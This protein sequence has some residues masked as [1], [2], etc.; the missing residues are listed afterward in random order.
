MW[1]WMPTS[2]RVNMYGWEGPELA[3]GKGAKRETVCRTRRRKPREAPLKLPSLTSAE[4]AKC[5]SP[6]R[7]R[8]G[9]GPAHR[10]PL[11][12]SL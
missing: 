3:L 1:C 9:T 5:L 6:V 10:A 7:G 12:S 8:A 2:H 11:H 4:E